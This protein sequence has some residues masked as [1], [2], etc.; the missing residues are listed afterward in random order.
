MAAKPQKLRIMLVAGA[1]PNFMKVAPVLAALEGRDRFNVELVHTGQHYDALMSDAFFRDLAMRPPDTHLGAGSGTHA[2]QTGR[3]MVSFEQ[4]LQSRPVDLVM[5]VG[6]VN[7][8]LACSVV[9][10]K[11]QIP[12][13]HVEAGLRS[14]DR[15]MPEE[16][17]RVVTD[18]LSG[19]LFT[20]SQDADENLRREGHA[21]S[22]IHFVGNTMI[23]TLQRFRGQ[24]SNPDPLGPLGIAS[25]EYLLVTLHRPA[26]VD[27]P[28]HL[29]QVLAELAD[30]PLPVVF[31]MHPRTR[32]VAERA[33]AGAL[34]SAI[35][36]IPP[37]GYLDFLRLQ[38]H[39]RVVLTDSG[40]VQEET[41]VLGVR[42]LTFRDNTERPVTITHGTNRLIGTDPSTIR[43]ALRQALAEAPPTATAPPLW[44]G[45]AAER[46]ADV[47]EAWGESRGAQS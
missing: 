16:I 40:G 34:L 28:S 42:C 20:T 29:L 1:R 33:G 9:A 4:L 12:L 19:L 44:D 14:F 21:P 3:V 5:V 25:G 41:T 7:S 8:T 24:A 43:P 15:T 30:A 10:A 36:A 22:Q 39:A 35:N 23:D 2:E 32:A 6:D 45:H 26:N 18:A 13:A 46:I 31:P 11:A 17:N 38:A 47:L 37:Q 27:D